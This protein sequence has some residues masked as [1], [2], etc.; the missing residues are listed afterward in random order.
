[1]CDAPHARRP[2]LAQLIRQAAH[3]GTSAIVALPSQRQEFWECDAIQNSLSQITSSINVHFQVLGVGQ[4]CPEDVQISAV[5]LAANRTLQESRSEIVTSLSA[6]LSPCLT[7]VCPACS[8]SSLAVCIGDPGT[9]HDDNQSTGLRFQDI[10]VVQA[11][12]DPED[13]S[14]AMSQD[15]MLWA[16]REIQ[17]D[18]QTLSD[19]SF[20]GPAVMAKLE[21]L[22]SVADPAAVL[23]K[24]C[25]SYDIVD[26]AD[27]EPAMFEVGLRHILSAAV[28]A[29]SAAEVHFQKTFD[30]ITSTVDGRALHLRLALEH[31]MAQEH[32]PTHI[33]LSGM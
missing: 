19:A 30:I 8:Q 4:R 14:D 29:P 5:E 24:L 15:E 6:I 10:R 31:L 7:Q 26:L 13:V 2:D 22:A 12:W 9:D 21:T 23:K 1:M 32:R 16:A 11:T 18:S 27:S 33:D 3:G 20:G 25:S 28:S 17:F